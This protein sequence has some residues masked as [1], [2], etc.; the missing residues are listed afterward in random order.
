MFH[1]IQTTR[2]WKKYKRKVFFEFSFF[3]SSIYKRFHLMS[4]II[5]LYFQAQID[6]SNFD[7]LILFLYIVV[8]LEVI[9][10]LQ[11]KFQEEGCN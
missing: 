2:D 8:K 1:K 11:E 7:Y 3:L 6:D 10:S 4:Y 9:I 5:R